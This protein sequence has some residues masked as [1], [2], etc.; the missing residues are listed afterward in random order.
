MAQLKC[1]DCGKVFEESIDAC[2]NCGRP[3]NACERIEDSQPYESQPTPA[4]EEEANRVESCADETYKTFSELFWS[5][6][7]CKIFKGS[8]F[9]LGQRIYEFGVFLWE[10]ICVY[11]HCVTHK[12]L[13]F[14]GRATRRE[15]F[16]FC[17]GLNMLFPLQLIS[18][19]CVSFEI[20][21]LMLVSAYTY[22]DYSSFAF[23]A[24]VYLPYELAAIILLLNLLPALAV[25]TRRMHDIG[26]SFWWSLLYFPL[27]KKSNAK[28]VQSIRVGDCNVKT[29]KLP[30]CLILLI[31]AFFLSLAIFVWY[32]FA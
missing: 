21:W 5:C 17:I 32:Y 9:D 4:H 19:Y 3:S 1:K 10:C 28:N 22:I 14:G 25:T 24:W 15:Y 29:D 27:F 7:F 20:P 6:Q 16:S 11:C 12:F 13:S 30:G 31:F 26:K 8:T 23:T 18:W 2:P